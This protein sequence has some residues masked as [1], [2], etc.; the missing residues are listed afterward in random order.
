M[1]RLYLIIYIHFKTLHRSSNPRDKD[2]HGTNCLSKFRAKP[3]SDARGRRAVSAK[4]C[5]RTPFAGKECI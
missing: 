4:K 1:V 2:D 3:L 5:Q